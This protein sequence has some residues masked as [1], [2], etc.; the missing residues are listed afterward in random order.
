VTKSPWAG[1]LQEEDKGRE[2]QQ[3]NDAAGNK[4]EDKVLL[5]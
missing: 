1:S 5:S 3:V 2:R 4:E